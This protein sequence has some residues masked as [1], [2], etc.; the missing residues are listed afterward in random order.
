MT[1]F[2]RLTPRA[3][4]D[5]LGTVTASADRAHLEASVRALPE[6]GAANVALLRLLA[7]RLDLPRSTIR[8]ARGASARYKAIAIAGDPKMLTQ[9]LRP[10]ILEPT[11]RD[12]ESGTK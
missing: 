3:A 10:L 11:G 12:V 7:K 8:I 4:R 9:R 2:V 1:L 6:K 5:E